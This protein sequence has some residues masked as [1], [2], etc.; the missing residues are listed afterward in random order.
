MPSY[1]NASL[2]SICA[3]KLLVNADCAGAKLPEP[4]GR[5]FSLCVDVL[6][7]GCCALGLN[8]G[9]GLKTALNQQLG[10]QCSLDDVQ[11]LRE[12]GREGMD[13]LIRMNASAYTY[14]HT[15]C[16]GVAGSGVYNWLEGVAV[17]NSGD[18]GGS[19]VA[20]V[21]RDCRHWKERRVCGS[22]YVL[23]RRAD[24][25]ILVERPEAR[26]RAGTTCMAQNIFP[27]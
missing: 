4:S 15:D 16:S 10:R 23:L 25:T 8:L 18:D 24:G 1:T 6:R 27:S 3:D 11:R 19:W 7:W 13:A 5:L 2:R 21:R 9:L 20:A 14:F 26:R 12:H 22:F 17:E